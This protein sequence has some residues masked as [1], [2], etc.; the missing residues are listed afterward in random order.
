MW[1]ILLMKKSVD[2]LVQEEEQARYRHASTVFCEGFAVQVGSDQ[3]I[4][5]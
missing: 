1:E 5:T 3:E 2:V 4:L